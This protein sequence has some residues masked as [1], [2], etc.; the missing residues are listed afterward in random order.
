M[1]TGAA[2][3]ATLPID[4]GAM[5][6]RISHDPITTVQSFSGQ[7]S[8]SSTKKGPASFILVEGPAEVTWLRSGVLSQ[9]EPPQSVKLSQQE[10]YPARHAFSH[11]HITAIRL[12]G[13]AVGRIQKA[14][15]SLND[16]DEIGAD[17]EVQKV[18]VLL[19]EL[20]CCRAL[21][22]GFGSTVG[23]LLSAFESLRG[24]APTLVQLRALGSVLEFIK[25][26]PFLTAD[27]A[28]EQLEKLEAAQLNPYPAELVEF[29][30]SG[31][32]V[33]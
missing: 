13:L 7:S 22:D 33:R 1:A 10:L 4:E 16:G 23:A 12:L 28:D 15:R 30:S 19:P 25:N 27:E 14:L 9:E 31:E 2:T 18:Q 29:L 5:R 21:G 26:Q 6:I 20:F 8:E 3:A 11:E 24:N 17:S 32:S